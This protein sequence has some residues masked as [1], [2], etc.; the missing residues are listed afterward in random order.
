MHTESD[1]SMLRDAENEDGVIRAE[2]KHLRTRGKGSIKRKRTTKQLCNRHSR[3][4]KLSLYFA[5]LLTSRPNTCGE[6]STVS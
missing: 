5:R 1:S 2:E 4:G 6:I 3:E